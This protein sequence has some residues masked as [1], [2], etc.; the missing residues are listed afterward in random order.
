MAI[1]RTLTFPLYILDTARQF[2]MLKGEY[3]DLELTIKLPQ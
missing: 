3:C 2:C 1:Y